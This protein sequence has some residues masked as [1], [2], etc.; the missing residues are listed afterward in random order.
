ML[1][2][3]RRLTVAGIMLAVAAPWMVAGQGAWATV[4]QTGSRTVAGGA[5]V[6]DVP[7]GATA[8]GA[9]GVTPWTI[10]FTPNA[11]LRFVF[12]SI[13]GTTSCG[14]G[15]MVGADG[16]MCSSP[17]TANPDG[18]MVVSGANG[19]SGIWLSGQPARQMAL[20]GVFQGSAATQQPAPS[21]VYDSQAA[22]DFRS[23]SPALNQAFFV[24]DGSVRFINDGSSFRTGESSVR[25]L[26]DGLSNTV[27]IGEGS[28]R[29][30]GDEATGSVAQFGD[31]SVRFI[32]N[33]VD[34]SWSYERTNA[35][36][37][38]VDDGPLGTDNNFVM[39]DGSVRFITDGLSNTVLFGES[40]V[41]LRG[42]N[43]AGWEAVYA[44]G[45]VRRLGTTANF[46]AGDGSV[47]FVNNGSSFQTADRSV[48]VITD[49]LSNTVMIG[50]GGVSFAGDEAAGYT[51]TFGDGSVRFIRDGLGGWQYNR[52]D[53]AGDPVSS[54]NVADGAMFAFGDGSVRFL[55]DGTS[56][57][58]LFGETD[59]ALA[60]TS[61]GTWQAL[62][63][64]GSVRE[65]G[66]GQSVLFGDSSVRFFTDG[67]SNTIIFDDG[68]S[69]PADAGPAF[70][71]GDGTIVPVLPQPFSTWSEIGNST[72][73]ADILDGTSNTILLQ[74]FIVPKGANRLTLGFLD[75]DGTFTPIGTPSGYQDNTG[76]LLVTY[77]LRHV[78]EPS[79]LVVV[80]IGLVGIGLVQRRRGRKN[81]A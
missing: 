8:I 69:V 16:G 15:I 43:A 20:V 81:L 55:T 57:T 64:D 27:L 34:G 28:V 41:N 12:P 38:V 76:E 17:T 50:E 37:A 71:Y 52:S 13:S 14:T 45:S 49:G 66:G 53:A 24:G 23:S 44:D 73:I 67:T 35:S 56:N 30:A 79:G 58:L 51:A 3:T 11:G 47:R 42:N 80:G 33:T 78:S 18:R 74:E 26:N 59:V 4:V 40:N 65:L 22:Y 36:G 32:Q 48:R 2:V 25:V 29:F 39:G 72:G 10:N 54:G 61:A 21:I 46:V 70:Y 6:F 5:S 7:G 62:F 77:E 9:S 19:V 75:T 31:G 68:S 63:A 1:S 60:Q